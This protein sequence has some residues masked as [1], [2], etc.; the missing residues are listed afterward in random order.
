MQYRLLVS[1]EVIEF[2][3]RLPWKTREALRRAE[4][5]S[6]GQA[7]GSMALNLSRLMRRSF[8]RRMLAPPEP[9]GDRCFSCRCPCHVDA[10]Q[11]SAE[12]HALPHASRRRG[13]APPAP[14]RRSAFVGVARGGTGA[15]RRRVLSG[16][17]TWT[18]RR[19]STRTARTGRSPPWNTDCPGAGRP[20]ARSGTCRARR[21]RGHGHHDADR[22]CS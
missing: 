7:S 22:G 11:R 10:T 13:R 8:M 18:V 1:I 17:R 21:C 9:V 12:A 20:W 2:I 14:R 4:A 15:S 3:E 16:K 6:N 5:S 19:A